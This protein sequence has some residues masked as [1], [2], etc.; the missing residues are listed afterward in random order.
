[1]PNYLV[2]SDFQP[3]PN[4]PIPT[5]EYERELNFI[6]ENYFRQIENALTNYESVTST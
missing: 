3:M 4:L 6:L 2:L 1:M 5:N